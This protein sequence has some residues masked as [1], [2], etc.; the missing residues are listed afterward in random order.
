MSSTPLKSNS[1][2]RK[3]SRPVLSPF[4]PNVTNV[5]NAPEVVH[6]PHTDS[7]LKS[8]ARKKRRDPNIEN[9]T[10]E[11][12]SNW[13]RNSSRRSIT[14]SVKYE[15]P[16]EEF[17]PPR[18]VVLQVSSA[19]T[20][21]STTGTSTRGR[22]ST[23]VGSSRV[24]TEKRVVVKLERSMSP[25]PLPPV[26]LTKPPPPPSPTEDP[27]L[28]LET[29][30]TTKPSSDAI[31]ATMDDDIFDDSTSNPVTFIPD[32][33]L[34]TD[35]FD[36]D[37]Q[38]DDA[39]EAEGE[40]TGRFKFYKTPVK[41]DPPSSATKRRRDS[42]G[43]PVS[44]HPRKIDQSW[45]DSDEE[46]PDIPLMDTALNL[47]FSPPKRAAPL[48][49]EPQIHVDEEDEPTDNEYILPGVVEV[50]SDDPR[51]AARA[52]A[53]LKLHHSYI[54][55]GIGAKQPHRYQSPSAKPNGVI[56]HQL[57]QSPNISIVSNT[58]ERYVTRSPSVSYGTL[59][60]VENYQSGKEWTKACWKMLDTCFTDERFAVAEATGNL[61]S[62]ADVDDIQFDSV[63]ERFIAQ[64]NDSSWDRTMLLRRVQV[65]SNRQ[66]SGR[67]APRSTSAS[68]QLQSGSSG[69]S[70]GSVPPML[71]APRYAHL[72]DELCSTKSPSKKKRPAG[73][74]DKP[75]KGQVRS[76][77]TTNKTPFVRSQSTGPERVVQSPSRSGAKKVLNY[78]GSFLGRYSPKPSS[79]PKKTIPSLPGPPE[80]RQ[81]KGPV[82]T[83]VKMS[84]PKEMA[85][86]ELVQLHEVAP[87]TPK[88]LER[89]LPPKDMINL[90]H[91]DPPPSTRPRT[92]SIPLLKKRGSVK[93][94]IKCFE[95]A[96]KKTKEV[97]IIPKQ[98]LRRAASVNNINTRPIWRP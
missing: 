73:T 72:R 7:N 88:P 86:K 45:G 32:L 9:R 54:L 69:S 74:G 43:R 37:D 8:P 48:I 56:Q 89:I 60:D 28:L 79:P 2:P 3:R 33:G 19:Q 67:G 68:A 24:N 6:S 23:P 85:P 64:C 71:L 11:R 15:P 42:W 97:E 62:M 20:T 4:P 29:P 92:L 46:D 66:R 96:D 82:S 61:D 70:I 51:A 94:L 12:E 44:P 90:N 34:N 39:G 40:F 5:T 26:D 16:S 53:I 95:E 58:S 65:L 25:F 84:V 17:T 98:S 30:F 10:P 59:P 83:P 77:T 80:M 47:N 36:S 18:K 75:S 57:N 49:M 87:A 14:P 93:D 78:L 22:P 81:L 27:L 41:D 76:T 38:S 63:I 52:A 21:K 31:D 55:D 50:S 1:N 35:V 91:I 13:S